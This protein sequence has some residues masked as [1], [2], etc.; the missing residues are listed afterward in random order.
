MMLPFER[1]L[2]TTDWLFRRM[3]G[4]SSYR[5]SKKFFFEF[6][7]IVL[8]SALDSIKRDVVLN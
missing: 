2:R 3:R 8:L 4:F 7:L 5:I 1:Q 6:H